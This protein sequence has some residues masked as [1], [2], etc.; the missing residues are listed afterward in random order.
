MR[1]LICLLF[2]NLN[3][4]SE[5]IDTAGVFSPSTVSRVNFKL[6]ELKSKYNKELVIETFE[7]LNG[8]KAESLALE[9]AK[10]KKVNGIYI[11]ISKK[12]K[13][14]V[15][16]VG[17]KTKS[18]F[19]NYEISTLKAKFI[20]EFKAKNFD[21]GL[22]SSV[23]YYQSVFETNSNRQMVRD[24]TNSPSNQ[25]NATKESSSSNFSFIIGLV[26]FGILLFLIIKFIS[27]LF[28]SRPKNTYSAHSQNNPQYDSYNRSPGFFGTFL[29]GMFGAV[30]GN[31]I[32]DKFFDNHSNGLW[33]SSDQSHD[34]HSSF[35]NND[36][37]SS[38]N[39]NSWSDKDTDYSSDSGS[40]GDS[41]SDSSWDSGSSSDF[42]G[43]GDSS[44]GGDW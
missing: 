15:I 17:N 41:S 33:G 14:I 31:W 28:T 12:E 36:S 23:D 2:F 1:L 26:F 7:E 6:S 27:S 18:L 32:Y 11:L 8:V 16:E 37:Y 35:Q 24:T 19:G 44:G 40:W 29:T 34:N 25:T 10:E 20:E 42:G 3:L 39:N 9:K 22:T 13:R 30:A 21:R 4:F 43:G 38:T 5:V